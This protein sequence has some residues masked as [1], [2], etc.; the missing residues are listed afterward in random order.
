[1]YNDLHP[2]HTWSASCI[3][4]AKDAEQPCSSKEDCTYGCDLNIAL[5]ICKLINKT[6]TIEGMYGN[7]FY[8]AIYS[9]PTDKPGKYREKPIGKYNPGGINIELT[10]DSTILTENRIPDVIY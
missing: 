5:E 3:E 7:E 1:M 4:K 8:T 6:E 2:I 10:M 9:C